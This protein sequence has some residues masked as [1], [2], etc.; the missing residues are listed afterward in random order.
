[1]KAAAWITLFYG[2][3]ILIGGIIGHIQAASTASLITGIVFG[4]L[5]FFSALGMFKDHLFPC[6]LALLMIILLDA[7]F[8]FR[9]LL[10]FQFIPAGLLSLVSF[11]TLVIV[12][13]LVRNHL[14]AQR[15]KK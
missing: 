8:T 3:L 15:N 1:M 14:Q 12:A 13:L 9:W 4:V 10:T 6:Y 5:L 11:V 7:F 2:I